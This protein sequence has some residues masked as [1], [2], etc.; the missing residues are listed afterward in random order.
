MC[1]IGGRRC[2]RHRAV[3]RDRERRAAMRT[4]R[5]DLTSTAAA[6]AGPAT[7]EV[8]RSAP[9]SA[10][11]DLARELG[12]DP[13]TVSTVSPAQ[14]TGHDTTET[15]QAFAKARRRDAR[16]R[17]AVTSSDAATGLPFRVPPPTESVPLA[18]LS[19]VP[20]EQFAPPTVTAI[21]T[22]N[23]G[24]HATV[25]EL[26][27]AEKAAALQRQRYVD[28][29]VAAARAQRADTD[30]EDWQ[31]WRD[32]EIACAQLSAARTR[33]ARP[34][35]VY[36]HTCD[37]EELFLTH[38][39]VRTIT[40]AYAQL[41]GTD[42]A[43]A[44]R[45]AEPAAADK[46]I[47][48]AAHIAS[49]TTPVEAIGSDNWNRY[50]HN[51]KGDVETARQ[52]V[53]DDIDAL[54]DPTALAYLTRL[55]T[56]NPN[57]RPIGYRNPRGLDQVNTETLADAAARLS[58]AWQADTNAAWEK[59]PAPPT[60]CGP[61]QALLEELLPARHSL[62]ADPFEFYDL[63]EGVP[64]SGGLY[65]PEQ[66]AVEEISLNVRVLHNSGEPAA[67]VVADALCEAAR[68]ARDLPT[69]TLAQRT[70]RQWRLVQLAVAAEQL[71]LNPESAADVETVPF[72]DPDQ[73]DMFDTC[74]GA[75]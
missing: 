7:L 22:R 60:V 32:A 70:E 39:Q 20:L 33:N 26:D 67:E 34:S 19:K 17:R 57:R 48:F 69:G 68:R 52:A 25:D 5:A 61:R 53:A 10:L 31:Q 12:L 40:E 59:L 27:D 55:S 56:D 38:Q 37:G 13:K 29:C 15:M 8:I 11:A 58:H 51:A 74:A 50:L 44:G 46:A 41:T 4:Y 23:G 3:D 63:P 47:A 72:N 1:R 14:H 62:A 18:P 24:A 35:L 2:P 54:A 66:N 36:F 28:L 9:T 64:G 49:C 6:V 30:P 16:T 21:L 42:P 75:A 73:L 43:P 45:Y 71:G 65:G